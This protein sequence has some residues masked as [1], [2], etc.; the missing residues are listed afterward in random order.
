MER[1]LDYIGKRV[2]IWT[3]DDSTYVEAEIIEINPETGMGSKFRAINGSEDLGKL[4][5]IKEGEDWVIGEYF[6]CMN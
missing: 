6:F 5:Y 3:A 2:N 1:P 4:G